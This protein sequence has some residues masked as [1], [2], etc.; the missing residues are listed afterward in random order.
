M[1]SVGKL[2]VNV[3]DATM[4]IFR[5]NF[6][7]QGCLPRALDMKSSIQISQGKPWLGLARVS[8]ALLPSGF[9]SSSFGHLPKVEFYFY[10]RHKLDCSSQCSGRDSEA[11]NG[12]STIWRES[13]HTQGSPWARRADGWKVGS[14]YAEKLTT[15][16]SRSILDLLLP[17]SGKQGNTEIG[18]GRSKLGRHL[19]IWHGAG[20]DGCKEC[21]LADLERACYH[22]LGKHLA[23]CI[24]LQNRRQEFQ[25]FSPC[26]R[27]LS[28]LRYSVTEEAKN[29]FESCYKIKGTLCI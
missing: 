13:L 5:S 1:F 7:T 11:V 6:N 18:Q 12:L 25:A 16:R 9:T 17:P 28:F 22:P 24:V 4:L 2:K 3:K 8:Q 29:V 27:L 20:T 23:C 15:W 19:H 26:I 21:V 14:K 10:S